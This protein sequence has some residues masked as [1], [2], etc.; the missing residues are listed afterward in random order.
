LCAAA[1]GALFLENVA[2]LPARAQARLVR[3]LR[4]REVF[5]DG[6]VEPITLNV[7]P[8]AS[9]EGA[10]AEAV[11]EGRLRPDLH[12][13]L[14]LIRIDLPALRQ[15]RED[16]PLLATH[17]LKEICQVNGQPLKTFTKPALRCS[18]RR[19]GAATSLNFRP[20]RAAS[21]LVPQG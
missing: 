6:G 12:E 20:A 18:Q 10:P 17:F 11:E 7:R 3:V 15:R 1:G 16:I 5:V 21:L 9:V 19:R 13:R 8:I 4:D 2:E 14:A